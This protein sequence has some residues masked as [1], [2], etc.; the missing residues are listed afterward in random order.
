MARTKKLKQ[1]T[2]LKEASDYAADI[3]KHLF[4]K[5]WTLNFLRMDGE[6]NVAA[7]CTSDEQY[8]RATITFYPPFFKEGLIDQKEIILHELCHIITSVQNELLYAVLH[9]GEHVSVHE[10]KAAFER[11]TTWISDIIGSFLFKDL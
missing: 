1:M 11:E 8:R 6:T 2:T 9:N 10:R 3:K 4:L 7:E 5:G